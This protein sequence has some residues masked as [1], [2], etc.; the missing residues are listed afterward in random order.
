MKRTQGLVVAQLTFTLLTSVGAGGQ[1]NAGR[2]LPELIRGNERF[3][4]KLLAQIHSDGPE[5]NIVLSPLPLALMLA[6]LR[7]NTTYKEIDKTFGWENLALITPA[8]ML[9]AAFEKP[10]PRPCARLGS[11][12][13]P[14]FERAWITNTLLYHSTRSIKDPISPQFMRLAAKYFGFDF[15]NSGDVQPTAEDLRRAVKPNGVLPKV[16]KENDF[17]ISSGTHLR[18]TWEENTFSL[19]TPYRGEFRTA[20]G[21]SKQVEMQDSALSNY[22]Y[23][24]TVSFEAAALPGEI[25]YMIA[26]L[27]A[28]GTDLQRLER[29]LAEQPETIDA[30]LKP[31]PGRVTMPSFHIRSESHLRLPIVALGIRQVF[32][33]LGDIVKIP[34]S[35]VTEVNQKIDLIVDR[36]GIRADAN[37]VAG[38]VYGGIMSVPE[39]FHMQ[40]NRPF[41]FLIRD[42]T[43]DALLFI[44]AVTDPSDLSH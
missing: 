18:T 36:S 33:D 24:N 39:P 32:L 23:A 16:S 8:H 14:E 43:T 6:A 9:L 15:V 3:G 2:G 37:T 20:S 22:L 40:L 42:Q 30:A 11:K 38:A 7:T 29:E 4:R 34:K 10:E 25:A 21:E 17:L 27:P 26:V 44:G 31:R 35:H 13:C 12:A 19:S 5:R 41:V 1:T 28:P